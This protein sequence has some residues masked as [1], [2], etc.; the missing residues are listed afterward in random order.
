MTQPP[1]F[2]KAPDPKKSPAS[3]SETFGEGG[4]NNATGNDRP[5]LRQR[6][7]QLPESTRRFVWQGKVLPA[8]W[9][10]GSVISLVVNLILIVIVIA[11]A[12]DLFVLKNTVADPLING[13]YTN[14]QKMDTA[15]IQSTILVSD[16]IKVVDT[17]PV[18]FNLPLD[19]DTEVVLTENTDI[20]NTTVYLNGVGVPTPITLP[21]GTPLK[22]HLSLTVPVNQM[23]PVTLNVPVKLKVPVDIA[24]NQTQLHEPFT[25]LQEVVGPYKAIMAGLPS[26]K[27]KLPV[28]DGALGGLCNWFF[29]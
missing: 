29:K 4:Q 18:V 5:N 26:S 17:I 28:C 27:N 19:Q 13:L 2:D 15:H 9:T 7:N 24:L 21:K 8:I 1:E 23:L 20:G 10:V 3:S 6:Y 16:T 14:F 12:R 25:G 22:I 11:L